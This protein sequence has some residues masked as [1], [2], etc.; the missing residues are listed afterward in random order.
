MNS[1]TAF[2]FRLFIALGGVVLLG[3]GLVGLAAASQPAALQPVIEISPGLSPQLSAEEA[4][5]IATTGTGTN[6]D[7]SAPLTV[8]NVHVIVMANIKEVEPNAFVD[9]GARDGIVW[10]I[11]GTGK[12]VGWRVPPGAQ[13]ITGNQGYVV[14]DDATGQVLQMG[15]P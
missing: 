8:T 15:M 5:S 9:P 4:I 6:G 14:V 2:R 12:F 10:V 1:F 11:R 3:L 7:V 13:P